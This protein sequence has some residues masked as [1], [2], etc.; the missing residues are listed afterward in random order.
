MA[1]PVSLVEVDIFCFHGDLAHTFDGVPCVDAQVGQD[2]VDLRRVHL[3]GPHPRPRQ[4]GEID[5]LADEP[6]QHL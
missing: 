3:N 4:P 5:V 1:G 6:S 2:L